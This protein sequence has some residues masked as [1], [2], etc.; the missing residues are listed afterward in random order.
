MKSQ[1]AYGKNISILRPKLKQ[2]IAERESISRQ[3]ESMKLQ[4]LALQKKTK[5]QNTSNLT[6]ATKL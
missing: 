4:K 3:I 5:I 2:F 6:L 1:H